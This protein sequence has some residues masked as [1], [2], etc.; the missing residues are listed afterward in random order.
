MHVKTLTDADFAL[1][2]D[3]MAER[4]KV[5]RDLDHYRHQCRLGRINDTLSDK[6]A[7]QGAYK[8]AIAALTV[9]IEGLT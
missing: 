5:R 2:G 4:A 6:L 3:L 1:L 9:R 8:A 7:K